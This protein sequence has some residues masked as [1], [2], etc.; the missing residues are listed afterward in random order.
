MDWEAKWGK[1]SVWRDEGDY[2]ILYVYL[3]FLKRIFEVLLLK[4]I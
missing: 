3:N 1:V 2:H 4:S